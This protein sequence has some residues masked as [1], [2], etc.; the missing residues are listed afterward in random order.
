MKTP[1]IVTF[2]TCQCIT[3]PLVV[4]GCK[5]QIYT[6]GEENKLEAPDK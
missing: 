3:F 6:S 2:I 1:Y 5:T 4:H